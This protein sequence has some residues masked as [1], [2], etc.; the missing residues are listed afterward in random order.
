MDNGYSKWLEKEKAWIDEAEKKV[1]KQALIGMPI[2]VLVCVV[3]LGAIGLLSGGGVDGMLQNAL[4][5]LIVGIVCIPLFYLLMM[6]S[7][8]AKRFMKA[9]KAEIENT[10]SPAE[11]ESFAEQMNDEATLRSFSWINE[12]KTEERVRI[13][14]D[15]A[16]KTSSAGTAVLVQLRQVG[17]IE[18]DV[19]E[20]TVTTRG[21]GFKMS[22]TTTVYPMQFFYKKANAEKKRRYDKVFGFDSRQRRDQVLACIHEAAD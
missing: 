2:V 11:L 21:G 7:F 9:M 10:L 18:T 20:Y 12:S 19:Q 13:S 5:G 6:S 3:L 15:Y 8:P 1:K 14:K 22:Q 4:I 16:L 17:Q